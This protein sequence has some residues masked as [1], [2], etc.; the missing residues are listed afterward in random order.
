MRITNKIISNNAVS[1]IN[2]NKVRED[3]LN[4]QLATGKK[5][6]RPS[7]DPVV[8]IRALRLRTNLSKVDQ[9]YEKNVPDANSWL[10]VT[11]DAIDT[12]TDVIT[13][14]YSDCSSGS[15]GFKTAE[16]RDKILEDLKGLRDE[17]YALG[18]ADYAGRHVFT[19]YRTDMTLT[20]GAST[21]QE[22][23][24][25]E[26]MQ[27]TAVDDIHYVDVS[28]LNQITTA[29]AAASTVTEQNVSDN[30]IHRL[31]LSY[32]DISDGM[33][34]SIEYYDAAGTK[35]TI[36]ANIISVNDPAQNAYLSQSGATGMG[37]T[38]IPETGELI[39]SDDMYNTLKN[40]KDIDN[41]FDAEGNEIDEGE[42]R[43]TYKKENWTKNDL[44][45][46]HY[47]YC[48][49]PA[50]NPA[51]KIVYNENYLTDQRDDDTKQ[52]IS[53]DIGFGQ[54]LRVNTLASELFTH[55]IGRDVEDMIRSIEDVKAMESTIATLKE[56][57]GNAVLQTDIDSINRRMDAAEKAKTYLEDK[58]QKVF[59]HGLT[60]TQGYLDVANVAL[61]RV[62][63]RSAR[64]DLVKNRLSSQQTN[65][66]TLSSDNEDADLAEVAVNLSN[67][68]LSYQAALSATAKI[69]QTTLLNYL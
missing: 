31:R 47:F 41:T 69:S 27:A 50:S 60:K 65:F 48:E 9:Y 55:D 20:F 40:V 35:Q 29:N 51:G 15:E 23:T 54:E 18:N 14:M 59:E 2:T 13:S 63:N 7:D 16:D 4:T 46:E 25:T 21:K 36:T 24:I 11:E 62:G 6:T 26:Q 37:A 10:S 17:L 45:P 33:A 67:V 32:N 3:T 56:A 53:Y 1:N 52:A 43:V 44:H 12:A 30:T 66:Q 28:T 68:E 34:P 49:T 19:G 38:F 64:L 42:I 5:V 39:L 57:L 22:Y 61:T 8:A 58:M